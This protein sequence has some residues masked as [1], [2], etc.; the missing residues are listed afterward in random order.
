MPSKEYRQRLIEELVEKE[1]IAT[2]SELAEQL[3]AKGVRVTQAT[4]SRDVNE[5]RLVR[6]PAGDG[7]HRYRATPLAAQEDVLG[8]LK[9][10][11][12]LFV[13][14][15]DRGE[16]IIVINTDEGHATGI[17]YVIDKLERDEIIGSLA[18]QNTIMVITRTSP[19]AE[20]VLGEFESLLE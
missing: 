11:F 7:Q 4:I 15:I 9:Q 12:K 17:A 2:Q 1:F 19:E 20:T 13:R 6:L 3:A 16:N 14:D 8:E 18:G 10:R 5:L